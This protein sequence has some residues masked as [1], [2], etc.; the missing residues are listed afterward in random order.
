MPARAVIKRTTNNGPYI[1]EFAPDGVNVENAAT[2]VANA[3]AA[4]DA[5]KPL[6][7]ALPGQIQ[8][9]TITVVSG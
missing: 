4:I 6:V 9:I 7:A 1:Y 8:R 5:I 3:N 2:G